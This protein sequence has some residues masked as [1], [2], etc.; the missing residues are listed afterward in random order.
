MDIARTPPK[1]SNIKRYL[2][3]G[4][5]VLSSVIA[6]R[7]LWVFGQADFVAN[8]D[9]MVFSEVKRGDF[10][11][12]VRGNGVLVPANIQW[13]ST[14]VE[15]RVERL[16]VKPGKMVTQGELIVEL[17]NPQLLQQ[18]EE[19]MWELE[20]L[21][22]DAQ[23][24]Q[25][26]QE[27]ALLD[28]KSAMLNAQLDFESSQLKQKAQAKLY[29]QKS[30]AVSRIDYENTLMETKQLKQRWQIQQERY[31][32]MQ[33]NL[34]AQNNARQA[35]LN[36]MKKTLERIQ[37]QV[38]GLNVRATMNSVVQEIPLEPGQQVPVGSNIAKLAQ[39][40][41][42]IAELQVPELQIRDVAI[43]Q[44]VL[45]DTRNSHIEGFVSRVDPAVINGNV[46][47]DVEFSISLPAEARPDLTVDGEIRVAEIANTLHVSRPLFAQ[48]E[49]QT[50]VYRLTDDGQFAER[51]IVK[52]GKGSVNQI[53]IID[54]LTA[55][56]RIIISDSTSWETYQRIRIN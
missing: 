30:G 37:H 17:S 54:G 24:Q 14:N 42:L 9:A 4:L 53:Q 31:A 39:L 36:K 27:S 22:A 21:E 32:K 33:E 15:A 48:S 56:D 52:L 26:A 41:S 6:M 50:G 28:Q 44:K 23:A 47:V 45:I 38:D 35:R 34:D 2:L 51:V 19:T 3:I 16:V 8:S 10:K 5:A 12:S 20:A 46:Q 18:L 49:S 55:G 43:G 40:D 7:Y 13:L 29:Q 25:V 1:T 11:V